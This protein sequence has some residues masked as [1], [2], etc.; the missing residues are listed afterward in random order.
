MIIRDF[1]V[2]SRADGSAFENL[3]K[4]TLSGHDTVSHLFEYGTA[5]MTL[6]TDLG[7]LHQCIFS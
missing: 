4:D 3:D 5:V 2:V 7:D 1:D 6:L